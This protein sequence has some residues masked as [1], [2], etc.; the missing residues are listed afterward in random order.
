MGAQAE[1]GLALRPQVEGVEDLA[2][3]HGQKRHGHAVAGFP[4]SPQRLKPT[5]PK[6]EGSA[7][8]IGDH[9]ND[10]DQ[11][12]LIDHVEAQTAGENAVGG[13]SGRAVHGVGLSLL[14]TQRQGGEAVGD[15]VDK[16]QMDRV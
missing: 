12:T 2:H 10:G 8:Q 3:A 11:N 16:Q 9:G 1:D 5:C 14:H 15:Q 7:D 13:A 6:L 4:G